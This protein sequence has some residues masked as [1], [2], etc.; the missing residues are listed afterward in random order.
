MKGD[1][2]QHTV[3]KTWH[4]EILFSEEEKNKRDFK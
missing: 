1:L 3:E 2:E 4:E